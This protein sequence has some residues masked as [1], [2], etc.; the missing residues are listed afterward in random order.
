VVVEEAGEALALRKGIK[1][2]AAVAF[3]F[4]FSAANTVKA[5]IAVGG[6]RDS[7]TIDTGAR[8]GLPMAAS[9]PVAL[10]VAS[11]GRTGP[12]LPNLASI[13]RP[14]T[15]AGMQGRAPVSFR[16]RR[17]RKVAL[18]TMGGGFRQEWW[19]VGRGLNF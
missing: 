6:F 17:G 14:K 15:L 1:V 9:L 13:R 12:V 5:H 19:P 2:D 8:G 18:K 7:G 4:L 3:L 11:T 16:P 10:L